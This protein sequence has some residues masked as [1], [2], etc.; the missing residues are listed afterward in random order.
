LRADAVS[1]VVEWA[2]GAAILVD[3]REE[4]VVP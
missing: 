1:L 4:I 2:V 3:R